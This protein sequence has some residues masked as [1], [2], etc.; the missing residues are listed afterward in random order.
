VVVLVSELTGTSLA[1]SNQ[2]LTVLGVVL[3]LV[4]SFRTS[5]AYERFVLQTLFETRDLSL[6]ISASVIRF[7]EGRRL[8]T[9][10]AIVS[11]HLAQIVSG[12]DP[13]QRI[14]FIERTL[15]SAIA[16]DL[17]LRPIREGNTP[18]CSHRKKE[19]D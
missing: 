8:W 14:L 3:G 6:Y 18:R 5:T 15:L 16:S 19:H 4:I 13:N 1:I 10:L 2:L 11:R 9:S 12:F 17:D 7:S